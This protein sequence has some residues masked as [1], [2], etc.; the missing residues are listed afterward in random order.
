M[1]EAPVGHHCPSCVHE[2]DKGVRPVRWSPQG[3]GHGGRLTPVVK[4]LL[5]VNVVVFLISGFRSNVVDRF[6]QLPVLI[7]AHGQYYRLLTAA[8]LHAGILHVTFNMLALVIIGPPLE[9]AVGRLRFTGV[10]VLSALGGSVCSYIFSNPRV[11]GVGASGAIFGVFGA[12]FIVARSRGADTS[13]IIVLIIINLV[14]SFADPLIDKWA[15]IGGLVVGTAVAAG[16]ALAETRPP[17]QRRSIEVAVVAVVA[18]LLV[19][20][21]TFRTGQLRAVA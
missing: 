21:V 3:F 2:G 7:A 14:F 15:H 18:L 13:G 12:Y 19:G 9:A 20:L 17:A 10:Y 16:F 11:M 6:S 5:A 1:I 4:T 8:F